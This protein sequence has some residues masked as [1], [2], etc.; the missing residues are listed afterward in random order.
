MSA[1]LKKH[2]KSPFPALHVKYRDEHVATDNVYSDTQIFIGT[3]TMSIDVYDMGT[4]SQFVSTLDDC[5]RD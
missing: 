1:I 2:Y 3:K 5:I 4:Y